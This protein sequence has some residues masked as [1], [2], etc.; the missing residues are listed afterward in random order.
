MLDITKPVS[1]IPPLQ[2]SLMDRPKETGVPAVDAYLMHFWNSLA[3][4]E[5]DMVK[6]R[7]DCYVLARHNADVH[8]ELAGATQKLNGAMAALAETQSALAKAIA[9]HDADLQKLLTLVDM[10]HRSLPA[11]IRAWWNNQ[12]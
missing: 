8:A 4:V 1:L 6:A 12:P 10:K 7:R 11:R 2:T 5:R 9:G 3:V